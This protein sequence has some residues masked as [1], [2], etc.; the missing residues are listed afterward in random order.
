MT[1]SNSRLQ[2]LLSKTISVYLQ[3]LKRKQN[4]KHYR[5]LIY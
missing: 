4:L 5:F 3:V 2:V 1:G